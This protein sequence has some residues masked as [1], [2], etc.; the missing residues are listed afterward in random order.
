MNAVQLAQSFLMD[1]AAGMVI[2]DEMR[3]RAR[4][5]AIELELFAYPNGPRMEFA[6]RAPVPTFTCPHCERSTTNAEDIANRYCGHCHHF[7]DDIDAN[8]A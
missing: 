1:V 5:L 8:R 7:C 4:G 3:Q 2:D 6:V